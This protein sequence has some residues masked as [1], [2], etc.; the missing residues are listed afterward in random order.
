MLFGSNNQL[1]NSYMGTLNYFA[2]K[3]ELDRVNNDNVIFLKSLNRVKPTL[4]REEWKA[5]QS[6]A[7]KYKK[8]IS[9]QRPSQSKNT[10]YAH[11]QERYH[12]KSQLE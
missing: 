9:S 5:H 11:R 10:F 8:I 7:S 12:N 1:N 6:K 3:K 4:N 2:R